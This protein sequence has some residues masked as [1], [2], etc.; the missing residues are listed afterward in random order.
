MIDQGLYNEAE[1][2][3]INCTSSTVPARMIAPILQMHP[4][5]IVELAKTG[6]WDR[7]HN[8]NFIVSGKRIKFYRLDFLRKAGLIYDIQDH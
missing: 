8:G 3:L 5:V 2:A 7:E 4:S 6:K 1:L